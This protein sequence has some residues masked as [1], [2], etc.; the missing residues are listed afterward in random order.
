MRGM[1]RT[2]YRVGECVKQDFFM[3]TSKKLI[4]GDCVRA[5]RLFPGW[6]ISEPISSVRIR[7]MSPSAS[8]YRLHLHD[9]AQDRDRI[10]HDAHKNQERIRSTHRFRVSSFACRAATLS[11]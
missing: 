5:F 9:V 11:H 10:S 2:I 4:A 8:H 3:G 6:R 7:G 1:R